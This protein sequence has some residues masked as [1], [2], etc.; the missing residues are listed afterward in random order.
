MTFERALYIVGLRKRAVSTRWSALLSMK[1]AAVSTV[2]GVSC[3]WE[4]PNLLSVG[5]SVV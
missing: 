5:N 3:A 2:Y 1:W 4:S